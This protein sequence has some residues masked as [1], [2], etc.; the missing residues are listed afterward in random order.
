ME[1]AIKERELWAQP[2]LLIRRR[3][4]RSQLAA[5]LGPL[6]GAIVDHAQRSGAALAGP[7]FTRFIEWSAGLVTIEAGLPVAA[8]V[9]VAGGGE[10]QSGTLPGGRTAT[11]TH[12]GPYDRLLDAYAALERWIEARGLAPAGAPWE[13]Y[14]TDPA[15]LP[16]PRDWRTEVFWPIAPR[17]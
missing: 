15:G 6:Y 11:T 3:V 12:P 4:Q 2:V 1:Y 5:T 10:V 9:V 14:V 16:D 7:P 8:S 17:G 13:V